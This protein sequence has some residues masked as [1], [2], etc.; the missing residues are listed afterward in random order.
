MA[1]NSLAAVQTKP[2][3]ETAKQI[4]QFL[5]YSVSHPDAVTECSRSVIIL[6][7]YLDASY[8]SELEAQSISGGY[9]PRKKIQHIDTRNAPGK[10]FSTCRIQRNDK[11]HGISHRIIIGGIILRLSESDIHMNCPR[12]NGTLTTTNTGVNRQYNGKHHRKYNYKTKNAQCNINDTL[13]GQR[14]NTTK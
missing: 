12:R 4:T 13:L 11:Y 10:K 2:T 6:N 3:I 14:Q 5:N 8:I 1:L 9:F 7:I